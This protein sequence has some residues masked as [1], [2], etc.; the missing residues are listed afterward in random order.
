MLKKSNVVKFMKACKEI[1]IAF[2][3]YEQQVTFYFIFGSSFVCLLF[4]FILFLSLSTLWRV[5]PLIT[6]KQ[7][8]ICRSFT[9]EHSFLMAGSRY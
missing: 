5:F 2:I 7:I 8:I 4:V 3:P 6:S 9:F 1:N